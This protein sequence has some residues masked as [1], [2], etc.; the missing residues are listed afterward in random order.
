MVQNRIDILKYLNPSIPVYGLFGGDKMDFPKFQDELSGLTDMHLLAIEDPKIKW[1]FS[2]IAILEWYKNVGKDIDFDVLHTIEYDLVIL[3][4][5]ENI[6][7]YN[8]GEKH[9]YLTNVE[10]LDQIIPESNWFQNP[11]FPIDECKAFVKLMREDYKLTKLYNTK[12]PGATL[13]KEYLEGYSNLDLPL[14]GFD[15]IRMP[16]IAQILGV[17][18]RDSGFID[19]WFDETSINFRMFNTD[20]VEIKKGELLEVYRLG[21]RKAFHPFFGILSNEE[22]RL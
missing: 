18:I 22:I 7:K 6:Y 17:E 15:E 10:D 5:L 9:I 20:N 2:D 21:Q 13:T 3:D 19:D 12:A 16:A 8:P 11:E 14:T 4:K 1:R